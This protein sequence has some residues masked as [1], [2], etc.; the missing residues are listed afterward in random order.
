MNQ[1]VQHMWKRPHRQ[2]LS[3]P[4]QFYSQN[5][6]WKS[7]KLRFRQSKKAASKEPIEPDMITKFDGPCAEAQSR[8]IADVQAADTPSPR[9]DNQAD[10]ILKV[11]VDADTMDTHTVDTDTVETS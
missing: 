7:L 10:T 11:T 2:G 4:E 3:L 6:T 5:K 1:I 8:N 9:A